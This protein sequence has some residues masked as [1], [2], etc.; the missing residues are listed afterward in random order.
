MGKKRSLDVYLENLV[1]GARELS[2]SGFWRRFLR[3][4]ASSSSSSSVQMIMNVS[5]SAGHRTAR[6]MQPRVL[7]I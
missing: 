1:Y 3:L 2:L 5:P 4:V 7:L 6:E